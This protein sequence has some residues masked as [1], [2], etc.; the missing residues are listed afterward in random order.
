MKYWWTVIYRNQVENDA[1][2][3]KKNLYLKRK[4]K[5][6]VSINIC[7]YFVITYKSHHD[8]WLKHRKVVS[9]L[10]SN[11]FRN[12]KIAVLVASRHVRTAGRMALLSKSCSGNLHSAFWGTCNDSVYSV[13][14][15]MHQPPFTSEFSPKAQGVPGT[16][17]TVANKQQGVQ[18]H[19]EPCVILQI[20]C[21]A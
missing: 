21:Q 18:P 5:L 12:P 11:S 4:W 6:F 13:I 15:Q 19:S 14:Q 16:L 7:S 9:L 20:T 3:E 17:L 8:K 1:W 10:N 2:G